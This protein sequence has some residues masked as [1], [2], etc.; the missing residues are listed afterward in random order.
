MFTIHDFLGKIDHEGG[1]Y[2][3]LEYGLTVD[4]Y[5]LPKHIVDMWN[6]LRIQ[7]RDID[8][9]A[10][11]FFGEAYRYAETVPEED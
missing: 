1:I 9:A 8:T 7:F 5:E 2:S 4:M 11:E 10:E 6:E 3:A